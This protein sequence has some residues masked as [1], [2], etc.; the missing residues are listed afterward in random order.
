MDL[1]NPD[2]CDS[3]VQMAIPRDAR[4]RQEEKV[5]TLSMPDIVLLCPQ[6][7]SP[8][9]V[10]PGKSLHS[11]AAGMSLVYI[12]LAKQALFLG[13]RSPCVTPTGCNHPKRI[14]YTI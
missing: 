1:Q 10:V 8:P 11:S 6:W 3:M 5:G 12:T 7:L 14:W 4:E 13:A 9:N 2:G